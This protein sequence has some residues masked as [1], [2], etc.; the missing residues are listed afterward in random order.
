MTEIDSAI[1]A[2]AEEFA[3]RLN[4]LIGRVLPNDQPTFL[5]QLLPGRR[6]S[7]VVHPVSLDDEDRQAQPLVLHA[8]GRS[9]VRT[10]HLRVT[11]K[12]CADSSGRHLTIQESSIGLGLEGIPDPLLRFEYDRNMASGSRLPAAHIQVHAHRDETTWLMLHADEARPGDRWR[13]DRLPRLAELHLPTG[14]D[15]YRPCLEDVLTIAI[16]EFGVTRRDGAWKA[17]EDG[18]AEWRRFQLRAAVRD[19]PET[20]AEVL[21]DEGWSVRRTP[22]ARAGERD[23]RLRRV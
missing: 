3:E 1:V 10:L 7:L 18:R 5:A 8:A 23:E 6:P 14:G 2:Q 17:L 4:Q 15:R 12:C 22:R 21:R 19:A 16:N 11:Y 9:S 13:R 20:A